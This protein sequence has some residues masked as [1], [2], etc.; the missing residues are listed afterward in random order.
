MGTDSPASIAA[1]Y[2][3]A[4]QGNGIETPAPCSPR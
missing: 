3:D 2:F 1:A 4:W